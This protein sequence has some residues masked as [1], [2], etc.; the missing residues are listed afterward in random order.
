MH[1]GTHG[2]TETAATSRSLRSHYTSRG[3]TL[4]SITRNSRLCDIFIQLFR[5]SSDIEFELADILC[6]CECV[7]ECECECVYVC[8]F[9]YMCIDRITCTNDILNVSKSKGKRQIEN[10]QK[11]FPAQQK[12]YWN[13]LVGQ[14]FQALE[15]RRRKEKYFR[16][17]IVQCR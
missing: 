17:N 14:H 15:A 13:W 4:H 8:V 12:H 7:C 5:I 10:S 16:V 6:V 9:A 2:R 3:E 1:I 11:P